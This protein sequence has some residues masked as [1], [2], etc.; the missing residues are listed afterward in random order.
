MIIFRKVFCDLWKYFVGMED[1][2]FNVGLN[3]MFY[4]VF[5]IFIFDDVGFYYELKD[6]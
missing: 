3:G 5:F 4:L 1:F 6:N 2:L